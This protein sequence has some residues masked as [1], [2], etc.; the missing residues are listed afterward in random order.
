MRLYLKKT[1]THTQI[2]RLVEWLKVKALSSSPSTTK[3]I[4][5]WY[6]RDDFSA[7]RYQ[8]LLRNRK[9]VKENSGVELEG[10]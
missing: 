1:L 6:K 8:R 5:G 2:I 4:I 9:Q 3:K 7:L 10:R